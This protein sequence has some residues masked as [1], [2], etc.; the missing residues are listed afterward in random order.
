MAIKV[1][2]TEY[3]AKWKS[4]LD[5]AIDQISTGVDRVTEAPGEKAAAAADKFRAKINQSIEDGSWQRGVA[6][7]TLPEWKKAM[8]EKGIPRI[9]D[10][11]RAAQPKME[12]FAAAL[13]PAI[14]SAQREL[15]D[16]PSVSLEENIARSA[17][18][19]RKMAQFN[20]KGM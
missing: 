6:S 15:E 3:G 1:T 8:K 17:A 16:M 12:K 11:T 20:Y 18:F 4:R 13:F 7:V 14:E 2:P 9:R 10:G 19:Q 5:G